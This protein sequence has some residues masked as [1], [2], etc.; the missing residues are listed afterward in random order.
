[1]QDNLIKL[2]EILVPNEYTT[3][4]IPS[5][6]T[7]YQI[8]L[9]SK[10]DAD[11][12]DIAQIFI[13]DNNHNPVRIGWIIPVLSIVSKEHQSYDC[14][15]FKKHAFEIFRQLKDNSFDERTYFIIY[16]KRLVQDF[17]FDTGSIIVDACRYGLYPFNGKHSSYSN[18][19]S[20][21]IRAE[22]T[23]SE[24]FDIKKTDGFIK[25]LFFEKL[26]TEVNMY[27]RF[28]YIYQIIELLMEVTFHSKIK[29]YR[30]K[31]NHLGLIRKKI[32]DYSSE[33]KLINI[34]YG[35]TKKN[36]IIASLSQAA[37]DLF[38]DSSN[39]N[40]HDTNNAEIIYEFRNSLVH[41]YY[42]LEMESHLATFCDHLEHDIYEMLLKIYSEKDLEN[43]KNDLIKLYFSGK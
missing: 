5:I 25:T 15:Y 4:P 23:L 37:T 7:Q 36:K 43:E 27:A 24:C 21:K 12:K 33:D 11:E 2:S 22:I 26:Q 3:D 29:S 8:E 32:T 6:E 40:Y 34:L 35:S 28:M 19:I 16:S 13:K 17:S 39:K 41:N 42:R 10:H 20:E 38:S 1:M 30:S 31:K 18:T 14:K 9:F